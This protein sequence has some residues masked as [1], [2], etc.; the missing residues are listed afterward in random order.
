MRKTS[1]YPDHQGAPKA[2]L[3]QRKPMSEVIRPS[4]LCAVAL[5]C[6]TLTTPIAA[7]EWRD[8][9]IKIMVGFGPGGGT[10]VATRVVA[11]PLGDVLGQRII[12]ENRPGAG[13]ALAGDV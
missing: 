4:L 13:G 8:K 11:E 1:G 3:I 6:A 12:V 2:P 10:D 5:G 7:Q 9:P